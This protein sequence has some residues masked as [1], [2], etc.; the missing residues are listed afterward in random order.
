[1]RV[2]VVVKSLQIGGMERAA[3]NLAEI[4]SKHGHK[5]H[6][7]CLQNKNRVLSPNDSVRLHLFD[8]ENSLKSTPLYSIKKIFSKTLNIFI[9]HSYFMWHGYFLTNI[10]KDKLQKVEQTSGTF[11]LI[12]VRGHST[13]EMI[14]PFKRE[15]LI[16][17]QVNILSTKKNSFL[18]NF[19]RRSIFSGKN[20]VCN[21]NAIQ[22]E[23]ANDFSLRNIQAKSLHVVPSPVNVPLILQKSQEY[24]TSISDKYIVSLGR[25]APVKNI[26]LLI[27][28]YA[29]AREHLALKHKLVIVGDGPSKESLIDQI[30]LLN[31]DKYIH[32]TGALE[33]P[34]PWLKNADLFLFTSKNEGLPNVL[35]EALACETT[36]VA[37]KGRG[38][39]LDIMNGDLKNNLTNFSEKEI[40]QKVIAVLA[41]SQKPDFNAHLQKYSS[42]SIVAQYL[43]YISPV[44]EI[45]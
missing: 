36:I 9:R 43:Q 1:M 18:N 39:T 32:L 13:I 37:T 3:I 11:D 19:Y 44:G 41:Q 5:T 21:S 29:Y 31:L 42:D 4:F 6:L 23:I 12:I 7:I 34:Y 17:Q 20:V 15:N 33:N 27:N 22:K 24:K 40:A 45:R 8:L 2:A 28:A 16:V 30:K 14:W 25:L 38:G 10:F 26:E 35:L